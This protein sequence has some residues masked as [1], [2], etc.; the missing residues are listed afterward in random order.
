MAK[1]KKIEKVKDKLPPPGA[2]PDRVIVVMFKDGVPQ[3]QT[4]GDLQT[5]HFMTAV[6]FLE[7]I[8]LQNVLLK[9]LQ[10]AKAMEV[11]LQRGGIALPPSVEILRK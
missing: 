2:A 7:D 10:Q 6:A 9:S 3:L 4:S 5:W 8:I 11:A 1:K